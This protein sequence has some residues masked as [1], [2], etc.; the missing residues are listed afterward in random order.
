MSLANEYLI[1]AEGWQQFD[2]APTED[3]NKQKRLDFSHKVA[4]VF[5]SPEGK[6]VLNTM[7][8]MYLLN[9]IVSPNDTQFA[10]GIK[11]GKASLVKQI[12]AQIE[13]S[14]NVR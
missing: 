1:S 5:G 7:V 13:L 3:D 2:V 12:M 6:E 11:Q 8:Q 10:A 4:K 14:N 9:D